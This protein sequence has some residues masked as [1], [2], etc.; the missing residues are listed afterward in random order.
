MLD[1]AE[2]PGGRREVFAVCRLQERIDLDDDERKA[3]GWRKAMSPDGRQYVTWNLATNGA[4]TL[5]EIELGDDDVT[6]LCR[7]VDGFNVVLGR[8]RG[9]YEPLVAQLPQLAEANGARA[10]AGAIQ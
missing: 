10:A 4:H 6:R 9:W 8:D 7:A 2:C 5:K 1:G 3:V